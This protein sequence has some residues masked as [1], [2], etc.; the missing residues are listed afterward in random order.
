[1]RVCKKTTALTDYNNILTSKFPAKCADSTA[2]D[3]GVGRIVSRFLLQGK[4]NTH[5][6]AVPL[7][8]QT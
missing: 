6:T 2:G 7:H 1:M 5:H 8:G 3:P 4:P